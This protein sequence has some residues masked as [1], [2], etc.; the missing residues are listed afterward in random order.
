MR[1]A[2]LERNSIQWEENAKANALWAILTDHN[3]RSKA[4]DPEEFFRT[5][6]TEVSNVFHYMQS[7][8]ISIPEGGSFLDFGCGVGRATRALMARFDRGYGVDVSDT[9]ISLAN[10][11][12]ATDARKPAYIVNKVASLNAITD[13]AI[14]F[15]YSH[16]VIQHIPKPL[17]PVFIGEFMRV[18]R[19]GGIAAFQVP[20]EDLTPH[21][22]L[23]IRSVKSLAKRILPNLFIRRIRM[24]LGRGSV[25]ADVSMEMNIVSF[26]IIQNLIDKCGCELLS[27]PCTNSTSTRHGG[28]IKFMSREEGIAAIR[29]K[30]TDSSLLSQ[31]FF[32][33]KKRSCENGQTKLAARR[34]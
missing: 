34:K 17:Q 7:V 1:E 26:D 13:N 9:M 23:V 6:H 25:T 30:E 20:T 14:D 29:N 16:I 2:M 27:A 19:P 3:K 15:V 28:N 11:Y 22:A 18:L 24:L 8:G 5:G 32:V 33:R 12:S 4:W 21:A 10:K 31:F